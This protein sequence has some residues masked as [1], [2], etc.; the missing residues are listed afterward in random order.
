MEQTKSADGTAIAF[1]RSGAGPAL[2]L[3]GGALSDRLG[4]APLADRLAPRFTVYTY[5]RRGR[6]SSGDTL[7]YAVEREIDD[8]AAVIAAAGGSALVYGHS[9]GA[10]LALEAAMAGLPIIRLAAYEPPYILEGDRPLPPADL[11]ARIEELVSSGQPG[12]AVKAFLVEA[13]TMPAEIVDGMAASPAWPSMEALAPTLPYDIAV[14]GVGN[15][16]P[17]ERLTTL[18]IPTL[19]LDGGAS[20]EWARNSVA[21]LASTIPGAE[22]FS[23][24]GQT[25]GADIQLLTPVLVDF[26]S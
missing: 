12:E 23:L 19:V 25:H 24:E 18:R 10:V 2:I 11:A 21:A 3:I 13:V 14:V 22:R 1:T 17:A 20:P 5:D 4:A 15:V 9:S 26:F 16:M 7:P 6:G 8:L